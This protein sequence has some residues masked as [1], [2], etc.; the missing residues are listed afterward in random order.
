MNMHNDIKYIDCHSH[1][2]PFIDDG[3]QSYEKSTEI[4]RAAYYQGIE[5][6][7]ATPHL[8][9]GENNEKTY[10]TAQN[11]LNKLI[12][13]L[14]EEKININIELGFE[15]YATENI[16]YNSNL[17]RFCMG[18][19]NC[20]LT[21][22]DPITDVEWFL[23]FIYEMGLDNIKIILAHTERY[24]YLLNDSNL[25][26]TI[27]DNGTLFQVNTASILGK[28]GKK[29]FHAAR[30]L[31]KNGYVEFIGTDVHYTNHPGIEIDKAYKKLV[32]WTGKEKA[33][34]IAYK[35]AKKQLLV[36]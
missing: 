8:M 35:N 30:K 13:L 14:S 9:I 4:A 21:E 32:K 29:L 2:I 27:K 23:D 10:Q 33:Y 28:S 15:V 22:I 3:P 11:N 24:Y 7:F 5:T 18:R 31:I 12:K 1:I 34:K 36:K 19:S 6:I 16:V 25:L 17:T 26:K 20:L